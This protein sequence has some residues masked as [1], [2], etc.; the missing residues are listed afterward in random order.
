[1]S[2]TISTAGIAVQEQLP[3]PLGILLIFAI[4]I[5]WSLGGGTLWT[6]AG[7]PAL[8][9]GLALWQVANGANIGFIGGRAVLGLPEGLAHAGQGMIV[10]PVP[11]TFGIFIAVSV[12]SYYILRYTPFGRSMHAVGGHEVNAHLSGINVKGTRLKAYLALGILMGLASV[13]FISQNMSVSTRSI[14]DLH[15][16]TI[17]AVF[18]G[19]MTIGGSGGTLIGTIVGVLILGV[20]SNG[21]SLLGLPNE[22][23]L[24]IKGTILIVA[25]AVA[26]MRRPKE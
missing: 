16:D 21:M 2:G 24:T 12:A 15:F 8:I 20:I 5:G 3:I 26:Y 1:M 7:I 14:P 11:I 17:S 18:I 4:T 13:L 25:V 6:K 23:L 22:F 19:G 9:V 10:G